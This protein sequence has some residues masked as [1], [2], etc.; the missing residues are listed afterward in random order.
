MTRAF[1]T[2]QPLSYST[3]TSA[4]EHYTTACRSDT[5]SHARLCNEPG[6]FEHRT[7]ASAYAILD[8]DP[9]AVTCTYRLP[10]TAPD[11]GGAAPQ[12]DH[13]FEPTAH[14]ECDRTAI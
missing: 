14:V 8:R 5:Q 12:S 1:I 2:Q 13:L 6:Y 7:S 11:A 10:R 9:L 4:L 3:N